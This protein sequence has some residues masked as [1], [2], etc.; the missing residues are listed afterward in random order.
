MAIAVFVVFE[1]GFPDS[2]PNTLS[3]G[4][5][6]AVLLLEES[7]SNDC[8]EFKVEGD[9]TVVSNE[10]EAGMSVIY[11]KRGDAKCKSTKESKYPCRVY[12]GGMQTKMIEDDRTDVRRFGQKSCESG[13]GGQIRASEFMWGVVGCSV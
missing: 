5:S 12:V 2:S 10:C 13:E 1:A 11:Y 4:E 3:P 9:R 7:G 6:V 8:V